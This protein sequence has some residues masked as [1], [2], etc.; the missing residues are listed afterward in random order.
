MIVQCSQCSKTLK[1]PDTAAGKR[2][3]CPACSGVVEVPLVAS[4]QSPSHA[5]AASQS[6]VAG[7]RDDTAKG[8]GTKSPS[9]KEVPTSSSV[10]RR[11]RAISS[12]SRGSGDSSTASTGGSEPSVTKPAAKE[13]SSRGKGGRSDGVR[14]S[15]SS[16]RGGSVR[17]SS[18]GKPR[19][20]ARPAEQ[21]ED[22]EDYDSG[23]G[24]Y[25]DD[26]TDYFDSNPF[27]PPKAGSASSSGRFRFFSWLSLFLR[28]ALLLQLWREAAGLVLRGF[29]F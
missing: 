5:G 29:W 21:D 11:A 2:V 6:A 16:D 18:S 3:R 17:S 8:E 26:G 28:A 7:G 13:A 15:R 1:V 22:V 25:E 27:A 4:A 9:P 19:R 12:E 20:R 14:E 24:S 10:I 23:Y